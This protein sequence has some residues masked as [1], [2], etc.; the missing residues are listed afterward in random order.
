MLKSHAWLW[1]V[2]PILGQG[3]L[4]KWNESYSSFD[5]PFPEFISQPFCPR[6]LKKVPPC[7]S[8]NSILFCKDVLPP[9]HFGMLL[10]GPSR[11]GPR[12]VRRPLE[13]P[14]LL[15]RHQGVRL[16]APSFDS[17]RSA[18][19]PWGEAQLPSWGSEATPGPGARGGWGGGG[20]IGACPGCLV[21]SWHHSAM[22]F[23]VPVQ[24][25]SGLP[26]PEG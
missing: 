7:P 26:G 18:L 20:R 16:P 6:F 2:A 23:K 21:S 3:A 25:G 22:T 12:M 24:Q 9:E 13:G 1:L 5:L 10:K 11:A 8:L 4:E 17:A 19:S 15:Q 14:S